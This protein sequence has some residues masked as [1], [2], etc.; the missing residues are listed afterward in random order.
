MIK[1][2]NICQVSL[3]G[4]LP[5]LMENIVNFNKYYK[6]N[7]FYIICPKKKKKFFLKKFKKKNIKII[8]EENLINFSKFKKIS[9]Y[10]LKKTTY[11]NE[12]Q[13]RLKWYYQQILKITF[14]IDFVENKNKNIII[15]DADT[16]L[17]KKIIFFKEKYSCYYG[18]TSYFHKAYY[19]TNNYI[20][21]HMP[22]YFISSLAQFIGATP[23]EIKFLVKQLKKKQNR[24]SNTGEW[25]THIII[26]SI[27]KAH[28][29]YNGSLFSEYEL[30]GQS[31]LNFNYKKQ[32][33]VS[34][35]RDNLNGKLTP[36]QIKIIK[37]LGF[38]YIAYEHTHPNSNS[39]GMLKRDQ[40][41][42]KFIHILIKKQ[43]NNL[44]RGLKHHLNYFF[45]LFKP[46]I[47]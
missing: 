36:L 23:S 15:W 38:K 34:G 26:K 17:I 10:Y 13:N 47:W 12:I 46:T 45:R 11:F 5:I 27:V 31:N 25:L 6:K 30:I 18:T 2:M 32:I 16:I 43:S 9:N 3:I 14:I 24:C 42:L 1:N 37:F 28:N 35:I 4:N 29:S 19:K 41:W 40:T 39:N 33:L 7:N 22:K 21:G 8:P 20:L 44:F